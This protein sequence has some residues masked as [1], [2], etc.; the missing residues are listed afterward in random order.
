MELTEAAIAADPGIVDKTVV[1]ARRH[2]VL[3]RNLR[4]RALQISPPFVITEAEIDQ[5]VEGI[6]A[7]LD[8]LAAVRVA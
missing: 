7:G 4:G 8:E 2:G 1:T 3:T 6:R 5:M